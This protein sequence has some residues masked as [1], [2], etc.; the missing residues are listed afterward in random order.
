MTATDA[1]TVG[2]DVHD[3]VLAATPT[4]RRDLLDR[5]ADAGLDHVGVGDH[6]S[7]QGGAGF[8]GM[9]SA[10]A[11]LAVSDRLDV[12]IAIY[13]AALRHPLTV[14]RQLSSLAEIGPGR[15]VLG[16]GVGGEDRSEVSNCG[17]DPRTRGRRL[18]ESLEVLAAL[19][20]GEPVDHEGEFFR[21]EGAA[22]VPAPQPP[23]PIVVGGMSE[24]A[25]ERAARYGD[26]WLGIF[27]SPRRFGASVR[28]LTERAAAHGRE[29]GRLGLQLWCGLDDD[30]GRA[31]EMVADRMTKLYGLP[32]DKLEHLAPA[33]TP[34]QVAD[35]L[36]PYVEAGARYI[37]VLGVARDPRAGI[38][39]AAEVRGRLLERDVS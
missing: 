13:Q 17:I 3:T 12:W 37:T 39:H 35:F 23:A 27:C 2:V 19:S 28:S 6:V 9:V 31:R 25:I 38:D 7:F 24:A 14:A 26:G 33:G 15:L 21:L 8:D 16:V 4:E 20:S 36:V 10:A 11:A 5:I 34:A 32:Y 18:D 29:V 1:L 30:P 22:V